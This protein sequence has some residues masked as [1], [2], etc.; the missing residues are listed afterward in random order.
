VQRAHPVAGSVDLLTAPYC[1]DGER[2]GVRLRP[3]LLGEHNE[4]VLVGV[5]G[6]TSDQM[7]QLIADGVIRKT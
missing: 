4:E 7:S 5:L 6:K 2:C 3:P 1:F